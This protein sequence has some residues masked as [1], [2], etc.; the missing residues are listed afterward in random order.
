MKKLVFVIITVLSMSSLMAQGPGRGQMRQ[1]RS[2]DCNNTCVNNMKSELVKQQSE[3]YALLSA[4]DKSKIEKLKSSLVDLKKN[5]SVNSDVDQSRAFRDEMYK[6]RKEAEKIADKYPEQ[7]EKYTTEIIEF[8]KNC[9]N[10]F[11]GKG[12]R[13]RNAKVNNMYVHSMKKMNDAAWLLLWDENSAGPMMGM[14][15]QRNGMRGN[16][17]RF[18][19]DVPDEAVSYA[20]ENIFPVM[21]EKRKALDKNLS[22]TEKKE[23]ETAR[24]MIMSR[25][26]MVKNWRESEDFVPGQRRNDPA[27]DS[28][29]EQMQKSMQAVRAIA[30][31]HNDEIQAILNDLKPQREKWK[32]DMKKLMSDNDRRGNRR[33]FNGGSEEM[34][35]LLLNPEVSETLRFF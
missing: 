15:S 4:S 29:R 3:F 13:G 14:R 35:F 27:F 12:K 19:S 22:D 2:A 30:I 24:G 5:M 23:I 16:N 26:A 34:R 31:E 7:S 18:M 9:K 17:I 20:K 33:N 1:G 8:Q 21:A 28:F 32:S 11:N 25:E 6:I 10:N